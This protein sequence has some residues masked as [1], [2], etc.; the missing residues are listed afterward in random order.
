MKYHMSK[1]DG[2]E[3]RKYVRLDT[4]V[5]IECIP[6]E[7]QEEKVPAVA[8]NISVQGVCFNSTKAFKSKTPLKLQVFIPGGT[9]PIYLQ[10]EVVWCQEVKPAK[11]GK[12]STFDTGVR[13]LNI[14]Q[15]NEGKFFMYVLD[16]V[17]ESYSKKQEEK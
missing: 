14:E 8:K 10:G 1:E 4:E 16:K 5:K 12:P 9:E 11:A 17:V 3:R 6:V 7:G 15:S 2:S 13:L